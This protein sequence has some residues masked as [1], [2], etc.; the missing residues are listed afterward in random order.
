MNE[1]PEAIDAPSDLLDYVSFDDRGLV[2][3]IAQDHETH[4]VL[5]M[6]WMD[7]EALRRTLSEG[8]VTYFSRSRGEYWR[9][10]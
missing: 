7:R 1:Q 8:R 3:V 2:A 9:K 5:M 6:A 4:E 10:G